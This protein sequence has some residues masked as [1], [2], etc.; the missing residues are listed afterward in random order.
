MERRLHYIIMEPRNV[1]LCCLSEVLC[2]AGHVRSDVP[3]GS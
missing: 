3:T 1:W 2:V